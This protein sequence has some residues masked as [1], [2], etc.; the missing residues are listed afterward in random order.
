MHY[1]GQ[2]E[3]HRSGRWY[4]LAQIMNVLSDQTEHFRWYMWATYL[5][6][7]GA[8]PSK[9][10]FHLKNASMMMTWAGIDS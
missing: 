9:V 7:V 1:I 8:N 3:R 6:W 10:R 4:E 2:K 5:A